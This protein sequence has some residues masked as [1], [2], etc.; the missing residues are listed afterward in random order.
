MLGAR[1]TQA[2]AALLAAVLLVQV[3]LAA[4]ES[5][6]VLAPPGPLSAPLGGTVEL[7]CHLSPALSAQDMQVMWSRPQLGQDVLVYRPDG[8]EA[9]GVAYQ[10]RAEL[11]RE[12]MPSGSLA[13]RLRNLTLQDEGRYL[14]DVQS[15][16]T[17]SSATL[18]L[19]LTSSGSDPLL[20]IG[21]Y[22]GR[23]MNIT[24]LSTG[25]YPK[26]Q[27]LWRSGRGERLALLEETKIS[28]DQGLFSVSSSVV[29][30][31]HSDPTLVCTIRSSSLGPEKVSAILISGEFFPQ[32]SSWK[33][34][35]FLFLSVCVC[36]LFLLACYLR[37][38]QRPTSKASNLSAKKATGL[39]LEE[40]GG[41]T[42][43]PSGAPGFWVPYAV[44][45]LKTQGCGAPSGL[46]VT[47]AGAKVRLLGTLH[48]E[49]FVSGWEPPRGRLNLLKSEPSR[50]GN[51]QV[52]LPCT[53]LQSAHHGRGQAGLPGSAPSSS[54]QAGR[55]LAASGLGQIVT[56]GSAP[57]RSFLLR[58]TSTWAAPIPPGSMGADAWL[59][60]PRMK[61]YREREDVT[62]DPD[63]AHPS[64][65]LA[66]DQRRVTAT[67]T[68]RALASHPGR[69]DIYACVLGAQG[70]GS[71]THYWDVEVPG[72]G[73]WALGVTRAS[74]GRNGWF[75][76]SPE[77]GT[78]AI[79]LSVG[80][81][82]A[83]T[84]E[85][86]P[87]HPSQSPGRIRVC[88]DYE[89]GVVGFYDA[90]TM[91]LIHAFTASFGGKVH[92]FFWVWSV[93]TSLRLCHRGQGL[94]PA[95]RLERS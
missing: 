3:Q 2:R 82:R 67:R 24:C 93:G 43:R 28:K 22:N 58:P 39:G 4:A 90:D 92:P 60:Y 78:W 74:A 49:L 57:G 56:H 30:T 12:E 61:A 68:Q 94:Q 66:E 55:G 5:F 46:A 11:L 91:A 77:Q 25:W 14:C 50:V 75:N 26:P 62:L 38:G 33:V 45:Y 10:G 35:L 51:H 20:R 47:C 70:Y 86:D 69:Y 29:V 64:L 23:Q 36:L 17:L 63:T 37:R 79:Q 34:G 52:P 27:V 71:G 21:G 87:L 53:I 44:A 32:V 16:G 6:Q 13:L 7:R 8:S 85:W 80:Q 81:Y 95:A 73:G 42:F 9:Q 40:A 31:E 72:T 84:A 18:E 83:V 15:N 65:A 88:L 76:F 19:R 59:G 54:V 41:L 89:G 1:H 48:F